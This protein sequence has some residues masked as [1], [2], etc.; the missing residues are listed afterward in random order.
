MKL[1]SAANWACG[2][3][4]E[5]SS[6][7]SQ[8]CPSKPPMKLQAF[9][10]RLDEGPD[11][12]VVVDYKSGQYI[13]RNRLAKAEVLQLQLYSHLAAICHGHL[14]TSSP[15]TPG[16]T[17]AT[18]TGP[19]TPPTKRTIVLLQNALKAA[20]EVRDSVEAPATFRVFPQPEKCPTYC[21]F[22]HA[23]RVNEFSRWK[24]QQ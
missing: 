15:A 7:S 24:W 22:K 2:E 20:A 5:L 14:T 12:L 19:W 3:F 4:T 8:T 23:C 11:G 1:P 21:A 16:L 18:N 17:H 10:D 13:S 9:I 6:I